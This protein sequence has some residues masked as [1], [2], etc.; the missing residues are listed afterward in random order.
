MYNTRTKINNFKNEEL[1]FNGNLNFN[2]AKIENC[3]IT[4]NF[5]NYHTSSAKSMHYSLSNC[6]FDGAKI[7]NQYT[8]TFDS[9]TFI[10]CI[11]EGSIDSCT[12]TNCTFNNCEFDKCYFQN[13]EFT[14]CN[15]KEIKSKFCGQLVTDFR[16]DLTQSER[17][18]VQVLH[19]DDRWGDY[20]NSGNLYVIR[21]K[22]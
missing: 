15:G 1:F 19:S 14:N 13:C 20:V 16:L 4:G 9:C 8:G 12:F 10:N 22:A 3:T 6:I 7:G 21:Q 11:F 2:N 18:K 5:T 17:W